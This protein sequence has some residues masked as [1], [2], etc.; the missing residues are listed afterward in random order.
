[1]VL[2]VSS[3]AAKGMQHNPDE[4]KV[5]PVQYGTKR[6]EP[7]PTYYLCLKERERTGVVVSCSVHAVGCGNAPTN[8]SRHGGFVWECK[9]VSSD[10]AH[11]VTGLLMTANCELRLDCR[12]GGF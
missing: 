3:E 11:S 2:D 4:I 12:C 1:M 9:E 10:E 7:P 8:G 5:V 6:P